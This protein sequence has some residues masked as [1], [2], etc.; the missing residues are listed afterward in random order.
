MNIFGHRIKD[1]EIIGISPL[2]ATQEDHLGLI[3]FQ[4]TVYT[5]MNNINIYS[6]QF[7]I[8]DKEAQRFWQEGYRTAEKLICEQIGEIAHQ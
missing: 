3:S 2:V 8:A 7:A 4:L 5:K 1:T 6:T